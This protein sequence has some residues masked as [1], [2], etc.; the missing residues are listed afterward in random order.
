MSDYLAALD[1]IWSGDLW[2]GWVMALVV[3]NY[4]TILFLFL[5]APWVKIPTVKDG[6]TGHVW[7]NGAIREGLRKLPKWW[8][9]MSSAA[10]IAAFIYLVLY[11]GFGS[12]KGTLK[13]TSHQQM[14]QQIA[15]NEAKMAP[16]RE[17]IKNQP[18]LALSKNP[19][20]MQLGKRLFDDNCAA[21]H[22]YDAKGNQVI[23]APNLTDNTWLYG[24]KVSDV[25]QSITQGRHGVMPPW[26]SVLRYGQI[27]NVAHYVLSLSGESHDAGAA[28][29]GKRVFDTYCMACHGADGKGNRQ[30]GA[31]NLTD[32][33]WKYGGTL[34]D[35]MTTIENGRQGHMPAWSDRLDANEIRVLSA[36]V[37]SHDNTEEAVSSDGQ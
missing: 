8:L 13:W 21:C 26:K 33:V 12:H 22:G 20:A 2:S 24:G 27:K 15:A 34:K 36:W 37:L 23:G 32:H 5:W 17:A 3:I 11:P 14:Q 18:V 10:F 31:A 6:T 4:G 9:L 30:L 7:A 19:Q 28:A 29:V 16:L 25:E 1:R 35:V